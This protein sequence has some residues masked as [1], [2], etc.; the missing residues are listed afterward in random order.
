VIFQHRGLFAGSAK[1]TLRV[2]PGQWVSAFAA[3]ASAID[4]AVVAAYR[5][6]PIMLHAS[7]LRLNRMGCRSR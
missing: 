4:D 5:T 2:L 6:G 1:L 3:G 7:V